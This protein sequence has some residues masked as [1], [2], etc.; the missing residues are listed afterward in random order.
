MD[1]LIVARLKFAEFSAH[2]VFVEN[3][4]CQRSGPPAIS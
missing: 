4:R 1:W 3:A 2:V